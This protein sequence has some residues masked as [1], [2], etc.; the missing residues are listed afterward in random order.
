[1]SWCRPASAE[2]LSGSEMKA[3]RQRLPLLWFDRFLRTWGPL[4]PLPLVAL[5][6]AASYAHWAHASRQVCAVWVKGLLPL[7][8]LRLAA[9]YAQWASANRRCVRC[10]GLDCKGSMARSRQGR[11]WAFGRLSEGGWAS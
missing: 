3:L 7:V 2:L 5:R 6:L 8:A 10:E 9:S 11:H 1:M 4:L